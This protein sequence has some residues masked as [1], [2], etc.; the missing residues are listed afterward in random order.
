LLQLN[1]QGNNVTPTT[2]RHTQ[3]QPHTHSRPLV[4]RLGQHRTL[5]YSY[6]SYASE[7][8]TWQL[9]VHAVPDYC[10]SRHAAA[11]HLLV[12]CLYGGLYCC[13]SLVGVSTCA[14]RQDLQR[15]NVTPHHAQQHTTDH[16]M[17]PTKTLR[18]CLACTLCKAELFLHTACKHAARLI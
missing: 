5:H 7:Q 15:N 13:C 9:L 4:A 3:Q 16:R 17:P 8:G 11:A 6:I 12:T 2:P 1:L 18:C 14:K 10:P